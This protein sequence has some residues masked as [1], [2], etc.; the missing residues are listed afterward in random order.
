MPFTLYAVI[1]VVLYLFN[2][3]KIVNEYER[4]VIFRLGRLIA[5]HKG[6]GIV[7]VFAPI[8][9]AV[10]ISLRI[11]TLDVPP[12]D[13]ITRDNVSVKVNAVIY[14]RVMDP[15]KAIIAV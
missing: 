10:K 11:V 2:C 6:P 3:I 1:F 14:C 5:K 12:Q 7:L 9:K 15:V 13:I 4:L 8:D